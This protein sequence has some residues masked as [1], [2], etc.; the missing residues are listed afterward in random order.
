[1]SQTK[2][3]RLARL[4]ASSLP[5]VLLLAC[6]ATDVRQTAYETVQNMADQQC[7]KDLSSN[8]RERQSYSEYQQSRQQMQATGQE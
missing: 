7:D 5:A 8:C 6:S 2:T 1:M 3:T 4:I